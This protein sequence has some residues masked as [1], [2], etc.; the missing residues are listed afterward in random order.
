MTFKDLTKPFF[1]EDEKDDI[2]VFSSTMKVNAKIDDMIKINRLRNIKQ[3]EKKMARGYTSRFDAYLDL[4]KNSVKEYEKKDWFLDRLHELYQS[5]VEHFCPD[6]Y[7][8]TKKCAL[9][10]ENFQKDRE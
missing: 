10:I 3:G 7:M 2:E 6:I 5:K 9:Q 8:K 1:C 4:V